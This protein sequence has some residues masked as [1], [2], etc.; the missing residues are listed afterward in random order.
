MCVRVQSASTPTPAFSYRE[1]LIRVPSG[2]PATLTLRVARAV[3]AELCVPQ[4]EVGAVCWCG[5]PV[6]LDHVPAQRSEVMRRGA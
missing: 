5:E 1:R 3:L 2:L 4:P 6:L